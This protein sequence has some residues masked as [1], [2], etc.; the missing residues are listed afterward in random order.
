MS[1]GSILGIIVS[2]ITI[3]TA[4]ITAVRFFW[5]K[6]S[7]SRRLIRRLKIIRI[8]A[9]QD[10]G[11]N[12][13][14]LDFTVRNVG[15][16][17]I[18]ITELTLEVIDIGRDAAKGF[19]PAS[20]TYDLDISDLEQIG[21]VANIPLSQT[22]LP[23]GKHDR[24]KVRLVARELGL[25]RFTAWKLRS[26]LHSESQSI[27]GETVEVWLPRPSGAS[28]DEARA[29]E[30]AEE[31]GPIQAIIEDQLEHN[32]EITEGVR[33][34][35][36]TLLQ[37]S[38]E[39]IL[40]RDT[41]AWRKI[42]G[43][44][45]LI[46]DMEDEIDPML[47][48]RFLYPSENTEKRSELSNVDNTNGGVSRAKEQQ[49]ENINSQT[50]VKEQQE[51]EE[52]DSVKRIM[53]GSNLNEI[54]SVLRLDDLSQQDRFED[55]LESLEF[56][57][58]IQQLIMDETDLESVAL[59]LDELST[60][61]K[62]SAEDILKLNGFYTLIIPHKLNAG[63]DVRK[64]ALF[65]KAILDVDRDSGKHILYETE[66]DHSE[67]IRKIN[68]EPDINEIGW[69]FEW[70]FYNEVNFARMIVE[71]TELD[72]EVLVHKILEETDP[73]K[74]ETLKSAIR[75]CSK[76]VLAR[77]EKALNEQH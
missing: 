56:T 22:V 5:R 73:E 69:C 76:M 24:F 29:M 1:L 44:I 20:H 63:T 9:T 53:S 60:I 14:M 40:K 34:E 37:Q 36:H 10:L 58:R 71:S 65:I 11:T 30:L 68:A 16:T 61:S 19:L 38:Q 77:I 50:I 18:L 3:I 52:T 45:L 62:Q 48:S 26:A 67:L 35:V 41:R 57:D 54:C 4:V 64:I 55:F 12:S 13:C 43:T 2:A 33:R 25:G 31:K 28:F 74:I 27:K 6:S 8:T 51:S 15:N 7:V 39:L 32:K 42:M 75:I 17:E 47:R 49:T 70:L 23:G 72:L 46:L 21:D 66:F 59:F